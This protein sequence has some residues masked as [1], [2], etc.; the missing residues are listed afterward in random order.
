[1]SK[2]NLF[3]FFI[4]HLFLFRWL[5]WPVNIIA[6]PG[7]PEKWGTVLQVLAMEDNAKI[8]KLTPFKDR[9]MGAC[10]AFL[11]LKGTFYYVFFYRHPSLD[12]EGN[13]CIDSATGT[14]IS[15]AIRKASLKKAK[16]EMSLFADPRNDI[17]AQQLLYMVERSV[18]VRFFFCYISSFSFSSAI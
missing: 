1:M 15:Q 10:T 9:Y 7:P 18:P 16:R 14:W 3:Y 5:A 12:S 8:Q 2:R 13:P 11:R 6:L 17:N 4:P